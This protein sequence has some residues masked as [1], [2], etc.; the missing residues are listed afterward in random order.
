M[1]SSVMYARKIESIR[2]GIIKEI[3]FLMEKNEISE[4]ERPKNIGDSIFVIRFDKNGYPY[5]CRVSK[6]ILEKDFI[7][8]VGI[9]N[10]S[11]TEH[12]MDSRY[13]LAG[14]NLDWLCNILEY[15]E[16]ILSENDLIYFNTECHE[17]LQ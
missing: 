2:N 1:K 4:I 11:E 8:I 15:I 7:T 9:D 13:N 12:E 3:R 14:R 17:F 10:E 5:E 6:V 16:V